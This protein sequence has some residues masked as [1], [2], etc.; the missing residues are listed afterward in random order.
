MGHDYTGHNHIGYDYTGHKY[1]D[2]ESCLV[3][4]DPSVQRGR[5]VVFAAKPADKAHLGAVRPLVGVDVPINRYLS[6]ITV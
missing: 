1:F 3:L 6:N 5:Q 2:I 4:A